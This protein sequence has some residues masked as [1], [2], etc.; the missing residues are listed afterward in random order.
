MS[1]TAASVDSVG[2]ITSIDQ[3]LHQLDQLI[4]TMA[5]SSVSQPLTEASESPA[6]N[7]PSRSSDQVV[8][9]N[10][11][12]GRSPA[13][14]P[15]HTSDD[16]LAA[17]QAHRSA[18]NGGINNAKNG[19]DD[20]QKTGQNANYVDS[21]GHSSL[22]AHSSFA[23]DFMNKVVSLDQGG[24]MSSDAHGLL[25]TLSHMVE[26]VQKQ[27]RSPGDCLPS[28]SVFTVSSQQ[29]DKMPPLEVAVEVI[30]K[31]KAQNSLL[32]TFFCALLPSPSL[33]DLC[34]NVYF[35]PEH[36][37]ADF[38]IVNF[39]LF[40]LLNERSESW[41]GI[42][43][44]DDVATDYTLLCARNIES[45]VAALPLFVQRSHR[46]VLALTLT[47]IYSMEIAK[48]SL[49]WTLIVWAQQTSH[50]LGFHQRR[51][52]TDDVLGAPNHFGL[53]FW[54]IYFF[55]KIL[56]LRLGRSSTIPDMDIS[57]PFP[58]GE[59]VLP[60]PAM[61]YCQLQVKV[62][63]LAGRI[64]TELYS[65]QALLSDQETKRQKVN[66][67]SQEAK[68][69][70]QETITNN[71]LLQNLSKHQNRTKDFLDF[72]SASDEVLYLSILTLIHRASPP[73]QESEQSFTEECLLHA[74]AALSRHN[75]V[76]INQAP[77]L[78][79]YM[80]WTLIFLPFIP[81]FVLFCHVIQKRDRNDLACLKAF[82][83]S[84]SPASEHS[85]F[86]SHH[87]LF[88]A[89]YNAADGYLKPKDP[90]EPPQ[91]QG[92]ELEQQ[93]ETCFS[94]VGIQ[95]SNH[96]DQE[97]QIAGISSPGQL[98]PAS[99]PNGGAPLQGAGD[100]FVDGWADG[101]APNLNWFAM[102]QQM[103]DWIPPSQH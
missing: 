36:D 16:S 78:L 18:P 13:S 97:L 84:I 22:S 15:S 46:M 73:T 75:E 100:G 56:S 37:E 21:E 53:L 3:R 69:I 40:Y 12:D 58:G 23:V 6:S 27:H 80:N 49:A 8:Y 11:L 55:E 54:V 77:L 26:T 9:H 60:S 19:G 34:M 95:A 99:L 50:Q 102:N 47:S 70:Q 14:A 98:F 10:D 38:L 2:K 76:D 103:M 96:A 81:F 1:L 42:G 45:S 64:Y 7:V 91:Q 86:A 39:M 5:G 62:A 66:G 59:G 48:P 31:A 20:G 101:W 72:I 25:E 51:T 83:D 44:Q 93:I 79:T 94:T 89:F 29:K 90:L 24:S 92:S 61:R 33:I 67:L 28:K 32:H 43:G 52:G 41:P 17:Q 82:V 74:R 88:E 57:I 68:S 30:G 71:R 65:H 4:Q 87:R 35:S 85:R 63:R